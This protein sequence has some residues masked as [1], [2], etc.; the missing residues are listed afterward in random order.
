MRF[1]VVTYGSEG[2]TR[3][4]VGLSRGLL[5]AGHDVHL[6][7]DR[8][9]L[10]TAEAHGISAQALAGDIKATVMPGGAFSKLMKEGGDARQMAKAIAQIANE[11]TASWMKDVVEQARSSDAILF[12]GIAG[13]V[14]LSV[15]EHLRIPAIG[16]GVWPISPTREF[17]SPLLPPW[18]MP[19]WLNLFSHRAVNALTWRLFRRK[20][21][22][23][24]REA[25]A[26]APRTRMWRDYPILYGMSRYLVPQPAD[27]PEIWKVCGAWSVEPDIWETPPALA[28]FLS[29]GEPPIYVGFGSMAGFDKKKLLSTVIEA[30]A[31]RRALFSSGWSGIDPAL[32][33]GNFFVIGETPHDWL[34]PRT[35]MVIHHGG[36]GTSHTAC[37]AG[38]PSVVVPFA[39]DQFFWAGRL[40][41]AG[42]APKYVT[43]AKINAQALSGM[44][45][46]AKSPE[47]VRRAKMLGKMM[48]EEDG[49]SCAVECIEKFTAG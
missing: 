32:L 28:K 48:A 35:S 22:A 42:V 9:T 23:A 47:V 3:P 15:A 40:A 25:C 12:S 39:G 16:L 11:N 2:D 37:R 18:Q 13:Y 34:F 10:P 14:G 30:V 24:R 31:G 17:P 33:P 5:R 38:V 7:A 20:I 45:A 29:S 26:Q 49:V 21:N 46:F 19:G 36:A 6:L 8:S 41:A 4:L 44:I 1:T 43:H 27:W